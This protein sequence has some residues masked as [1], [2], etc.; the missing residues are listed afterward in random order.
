M[1]PEVY[2]PLA[3]QHGLCK[4]VLEHIYGEYSELSHSKHKVLLAHNYRT[5]SDILRLLSKFFYRDKLRSCNVIKRH[6]DYKPLA[7]LKSNG[8]E[9][10]SP[11]FD[12]YFNEE[13]GEKIISFL[14]EAFLSKWPVTEWGQLNDNP[15]SIG[16]LTTEY[17][18][19][20]I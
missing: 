5:H 10:Y 1:N 8:K 12:S 2:S 4:S 13:E 14:K 11:E 9:I 17:A 7:L 18:Q 20:Y 16:I 3:K 19:V 15:N 6:P